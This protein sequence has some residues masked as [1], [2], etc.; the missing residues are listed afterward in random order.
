MGRV[1]IALENSNHGSGKLDRFADELFFPDGGSAGD[2][3]ARSSGACPVLPDFTPSQA[4]VQ[5]QEA[6]VDEEKQLQ[7]VWFQL[8]RTEQ[9]RFGHCFSLMIL[10]AL[11]L[12]L[13]ENREVAS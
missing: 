8:S 10:K 2:S 1:A 4:H 7:Q 11:D 5:G 6:F 9:R 12:R 3:A 13:C